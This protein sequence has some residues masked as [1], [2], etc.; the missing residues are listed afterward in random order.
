MHETRVTTADFVKNFGE[1]SDKALTDPLT[2]TKNGRDRLVVMSVD[3]YARL[4]R[5]DRRV[6]LAHELPD[7]IRQALSR[8]DDIPSEAYAL[9]YEVKD[10]KL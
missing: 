6:Y 8:T 9:N 2:I 3:E 7:D 1:L 4:K 5:R 10:W